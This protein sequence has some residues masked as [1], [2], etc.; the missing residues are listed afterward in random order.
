MTTRWE[1]IRVGDEL[2]AV[3]KTPGVTDLVKYS[4]GSGD[5]NPLH[6]DYDFP[7]SK[8]LGSIIVHGRYKYAALGQVVSDWLGHSGRVRS[9][10]CQYRGMDFPD[11]E[12]VCGGKVAEKWEQDGK[13]LVKLQLWTQNPEGK[14]TTPGEAVVE[15]A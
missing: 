13:R 7:Q 5:F 3:R 14:K 9:I 15:V 1:S 2:P 4:A 12:M 11:Q 6:H 10:S 8:M